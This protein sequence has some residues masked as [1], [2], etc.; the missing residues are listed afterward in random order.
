MTEAQIGTGRLLTTPAHKPGGVVTGAARGIGEAI[1]LRLAQIGVSCLTARDAARLTQVKAAIEQQSGKAVVLPCDLT[2]P[3]AVA[4]FGANPREVWPL[5]HLVNNAG[6]AVL[7]KA[8]IDLPVEE[9]DQLSAPMV[10]PFNDPGVGAH[11]DRGKGR[12][13]HQHLIPGGKECPASRRCLFR[14]QMDQWAHLFGRGRTAPVQRACLAH[15]SRFRHAGFG[16][17]KHQRTAPGWS[18]R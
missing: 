16:A 10:R 12:S 13:Y 4:A 11:D 6:I 7:R 1:A 2:N 5:R 8:L 9:W 15:S 14:V 3:K 17:G 18:S